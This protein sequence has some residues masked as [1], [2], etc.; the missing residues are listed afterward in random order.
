MWFVSRNIPEVF[1]SYKSRVFA[2]E[3]VDIENRVFERSGIQ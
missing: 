1:I 3:K 2:E